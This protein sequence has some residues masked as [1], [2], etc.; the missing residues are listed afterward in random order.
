MIMVL[1]T[2]FTAT[3]AE[4]MLTAPTADTPESW[5][6][7]VLGGPVL[8]LIGRMTFEYQVFGRITPFR[9]LWP[10]LLLVISPG[11]LELPPLAVASTVVVIFIAMVTTDAMRIR[12]RRAP[13]EIHLSIPDD[14]KPGGPT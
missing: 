4:L 13:A 2:V 6:G 3:G 9:L 8:F 14:N 11:M 7:F 10:A 12:R 1:G 5:L